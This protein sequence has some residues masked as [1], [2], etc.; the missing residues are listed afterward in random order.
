M[1]LNRFDDIDI[2]KY[3]DLINSNIRKGFIYELKKDYNKALDYYLRTD[4]E[5]IMERGLYLRNK[6]DL[7]Q[8]KEELE[9]GNM[10]FIKELEN[11]RINKTI[12]NF[13]NACLET[14]YNEN[15]FKK[16]MHTFQLEWHKNCARYGNYHSMYYLALAYV[17]GYPCNSDQDL[18][19][20]YAI[21]AFNS[22][23]KKA[24]LL[25]GMLYEE[26]YGCKKD[27]NLAIKYYKIAADDNVIGAM[28]RLNSIYREGKDG[29]IRDEKEANKYIYIDKL[30]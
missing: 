21:S 12:K 15:R 14:S 11:K 4:H 25:L 18:A 30:I 3:K 5:D 19:F 1:Q 2:N 22:G 24:A 9:K 17:K 20:Y 8:L 7:K 29:I 23:Y 6:E 26:G 10:N 27:M 16:L 13:W 28:L